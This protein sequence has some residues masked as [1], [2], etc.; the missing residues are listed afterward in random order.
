MIGGVVA[1]IVEMVLAPVKAR[2][3]LV[4]CLATSL[5]QINEMEKCIAYGIE[6]G[7]KIDVFAQANYERF[8]RASGKANGAL[9]A[10]ET[11]RRWE[12][13]TT[14]IPSLLDSPVPLCSKEPRIKGSFEGL[15]LIYSEVSLV[16]SECYTEC[17]RTCQVLFVLHQIVDKM[18]NMLQLR[19]AYGSGPLEELN[20]S[21]LYIDSLKS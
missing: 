4:E 13:L 12:S 14:A 6:E 18:E 8:E 2:T 20:V 11:F 21:F 17:N 5:Y 1:V 10:A 3:R 15:A 16:P 7:K 9:A 19:V